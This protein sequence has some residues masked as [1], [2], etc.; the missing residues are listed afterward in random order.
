MDLYVPHGKIFLQLGRLSSTVGSAFGIDIDFGFPVFENSTL[1][2]TTRLSGSTYT[3]SSSL[4]AGANGSVVGSLMGT[5]GVPPEQ[6]PA[7][8]AVA[9]AE[10]RVFLWRTA[11]LDL[12]DDGR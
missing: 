6:E 11:A 12:P 7:E 5:S 9:V 4:K 2:T 1:P 3:R 10:E 8:V